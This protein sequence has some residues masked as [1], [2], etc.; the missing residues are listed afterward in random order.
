MN[1][2]FNN[3]IEKY[4]SNTYF[5]DKQ[6]LRDYSVCLFNSNNRVSISVIFEDIEELFDINKDL[7]A[8]QMLNWLNIN[9]LN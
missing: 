6:T 3:L 1:N 9:I 2:V 4:L 7:T 5:V 8:Q